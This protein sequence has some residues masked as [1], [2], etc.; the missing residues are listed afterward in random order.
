MKYKSKNGSISLA[1]VMPFCLAV[2]C[3]FAMSCTGKKT[4][5]REVCGT[6]DGPVTGV[7]MPD[8]SGLQGAQWTTANV[9]H[10]TGVHVEQLCRVGYKGDSAYVAASVDPYDVQQ[11]FCQRLGYT[12]DGEQITLYLDDAPITTVT[13]TVTDM[14]GFDNVAVWVG[15]QIRYDLGGKQPRV[16]IT[17]GVK[18]VVGLILHYDDMPTFTAAVNLSEGEVELSDI[19]IERE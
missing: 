14:G 7:A 4:E 2:L 16:C 12:I 13:N 10:G 15:E 5:L 18:F 17:P 19:K 3:L 9:M 11:A 6:L 1:F 8:L